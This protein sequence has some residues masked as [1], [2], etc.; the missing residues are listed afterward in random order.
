MKTSKLIRFWLS[1][2][3]VVFGKLLRIALYLLVMGMF[4]EYSYDENEPFTTY[5]AAYF[6]V[7]LGLIKKVL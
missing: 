6:F 3:E 2:N 1:R 7:W 4:I 5:Q